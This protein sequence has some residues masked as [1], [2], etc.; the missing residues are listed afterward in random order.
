MRRRLLQ[1]GWRA[2]LPTAVLDADRLQLPERW[3]SLVLPP[4]H[5]W[6]RCWSLPPL[7]PEQRISLEQ[8]WLASAP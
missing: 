3:R 4:D 6:N 5:L 8:R 7:S 1:E 2:P